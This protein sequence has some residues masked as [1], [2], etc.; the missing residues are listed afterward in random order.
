[1]QSNQT[2]QLQS[3]NKIQTRNFFVFNCNHHNLP[4]W[5]EVYFLF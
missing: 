2:N 4:A 1:L 5:L 3:S